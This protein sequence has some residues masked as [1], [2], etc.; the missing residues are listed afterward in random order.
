MKM[1]AADPRGQ[2]LNYDDIKIASDALLLNS[3]KEKLQ[4]SIGREM[5]Q[6]EFNR[7]G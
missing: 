6:F 2:F 3:R 7:I 5:C 4:H 1:N